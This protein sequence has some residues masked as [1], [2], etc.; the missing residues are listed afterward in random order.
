MPTSNTRVHAASLSAGAVDE[1]IIVSLVQMGGLFTAA[2]SHTEP[3]YI[4]CYLT[5]VPCIDIDECAEAT[6]NC[7]VICTNTNGSY[8]CSCLYPQSPS[9]TSPEQCASGTFLGQY[10]I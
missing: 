4:I 3:N 5:S 10:S 1:P 8:E 2:R 7:A 6:D 9:S